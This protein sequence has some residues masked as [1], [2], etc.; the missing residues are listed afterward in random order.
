MRGYVKRFSW[1]EAANKF[2]ICS[3]FPF[4]AGFW[5]ILLDFLMEDINLKSRMS[6]FHPLAALDLFSKCSKR[7]RKCWRTL[8]G[9]TIR[10]QDPP[11]LHKKRL[12]SFS[13]FYRFLRAPSRIFQ[14]PRFWNF[15][16]IFLLSRIREAEKLCN[17]ALLFSPVSHKIRPF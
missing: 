3:L 14:I 10:P 11:S 5:L 4:I 16:D 6:K 12:S 1:R 9:L 8:S 13:L 17:P 7:L 2:E 15:N